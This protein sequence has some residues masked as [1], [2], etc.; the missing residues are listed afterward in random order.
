MNT[1][2]CWT[3][4]R[5][6]SNVVAEY[7]GEFGSAHST[8]KSWCFDSIRPRRSILPNKLVSTALFRTKND[9]N[10]K[11]TPYIA[12]E[13]RRW[14]L[15]CGI[16]VSVGVSTIFH[17]FGLFF[18]CFQLQYDIIRLEHRNKIHRIF[19]ILLESMQIYRLPFVSNPVAVRW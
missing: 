14:K 7:N 8:S 12:L 18:Q 1:F 16:S 3:Y 13:F 5:I 17:Q 15:P 2:V 9:M 11:Y 6:S 4:S 19:F 10:N